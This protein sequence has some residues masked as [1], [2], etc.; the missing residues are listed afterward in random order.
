[1]SKLL[2]Y[3]EPTITIIGSFEDLTRGPYFKTSLAAAAIGITMAFS[4]PTAQAAGVCKPGDPN[5]YG[6]NDGIPCGAGG[7]PDVADAYC[8]NH[9]CYVDGKNIGF[10]GFS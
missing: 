2:S 8:F 5:P 1:L 3:E 4:T 6:F 10:Q 7:Y 9:P